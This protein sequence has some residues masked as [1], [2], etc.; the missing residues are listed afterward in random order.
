MTLHNYIHIIAAGPGERGIRRGDPSQSI[1]ASSGPGLDADPGLVSMMA[2]RPFLRGT[3]RPYRAN[4]CNGL[5]EIHW[6]AG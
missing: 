5:G 4:W 6:Q 2:G 1:C 3:G